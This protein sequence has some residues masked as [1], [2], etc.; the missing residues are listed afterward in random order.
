MFTHKKDGLVFYYNFDENK[1]S[2]REELERL[3]GI[4][5]EKNVLLKSFYV[6]YYNVEGR[7]VPILFYNESGENRQQRRAR[8]RFSKS[9]SYIKNIP[10]DEQR[11]NQQSR[12]KHMETQKEKRQHRK[13]KRKVK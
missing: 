1:E 11:D 8:E 9:N 6:K 7:K 2:D 12:T 13:M 3:K 4:H 5:G 10:Y